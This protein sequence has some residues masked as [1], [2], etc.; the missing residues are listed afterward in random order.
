MFWL[1]SGIFVVAI[2]GTVSTV[3]KIFHQKT[4]VKDLLVHK[5]LRYIKSWRYL[6]IYFMYF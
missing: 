6:C 5:D 4:K 2:A 1:L 3:R